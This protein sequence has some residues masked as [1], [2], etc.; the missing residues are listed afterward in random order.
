MLKRDR[1]TRKK[2][3]EV[4]EEIVIDFSVPTTNYKRLKKI[5]EYESEEEDSVGE[6]D[7]FSEDIDSEEED[8]RKA[9][10]LSLKDRLTGEEYDFT[11]T[12]VSSTI[13]PTSTNSTYKLS[14]NKATG[15][16]LSTLTKNKRNIDM[17]SEEQELDF[18]F[19][20]TSHGS[21]KKVEDDDVIDSST[22]STS[23]TRVPTLSTFSTPTT[24]TISTTANITRYTTDQEFKKLVDLVL[25]WEVTRSLSKDKVI[26]M[27]IILLDGDP[28]IYKKKGTLILRDPVLIK[29][30]HPIFKRDKDI[31][32]IFSKVAKAI[33]QKQG[34]ERVELEDCTRYINSGAPKSTM[35]ELITSILNLDLLSPMI[36]SRKS[37]GILVDTIITAYNSNQK[38]NYPQLSDDIGFDKMDNPLN[39]R[40]ED[41]AH[42]VRAK[43]VSHRHIAPSYASLDTVFAKIC[44]AVSTEDKNIGSSFNLLDREMESKLF[45]SKSTKN[46]NIDTLE[47]LRLAIKIV[48]ARISRPPSKSTKERL[49]MLTLQNFLAISPGSSN[50]IWRFIIELSMGIQMVGQK[51]NL[52]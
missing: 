19:P 9:T 40:L 41:I 2:E 13:T 5:K 12:S 8:I 37:I 48:E 36:F 11:S 6:E 18:S 34:Y 46:V 16:N 31:N 25:G 4:M 32:I 22:T 30:V 21:F 42:Y 23:T 52:I 3:E 47:K 20:K 28:R 7:S 50:L 17:E 15:T 51:I 29:K 38:V 33:S 35:E 43:L 14:N 44:D 1:K 26:T 45:K 39:T 10:Q 49:A 27:M 24:P